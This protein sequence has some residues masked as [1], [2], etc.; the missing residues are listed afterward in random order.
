MTTNLNPLDKN[1]LD[2]VLSV[3]IAQFLNTDFTVKKWASALNMTVPYLSKLLREQTGKPPSVH[4]RDTRLQHARRLLAETDLLIL[5]V[6]TASGFEDN[7]YFSRI[8]KRIFTL[9]PS[10]W[11]L[12]HQKG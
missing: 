4:L 5:E 3:L 8:F 10:D 1:R 7:N 9:S 6:A 12:L 2:V 11:R